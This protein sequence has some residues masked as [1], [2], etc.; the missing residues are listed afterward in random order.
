[1]AMARKIKQVLSILLVVVVS[2][3]TM[4][5]YAMHL[6]QKNTDAC[7]LELKTAERA[8]SIKSEYELLVAAAELAACAQGKSGW[9]ERFL[10]N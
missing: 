4:R 7:R 3:T 6:N 5:A 10:L 8:K 2:F 9:L 1:M